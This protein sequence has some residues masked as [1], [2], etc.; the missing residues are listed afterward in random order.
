MF[1]QL[2]PDTQL[3]K[4]DHQTCVLDQQFIYSLRHA[5]GHQLEPARLVAMA[6]ACVAVCSYCVFL[7]AGYAKV[8]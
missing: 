8:S 3:K 7:C 2:V 5:A 4:A 1:G 6:R